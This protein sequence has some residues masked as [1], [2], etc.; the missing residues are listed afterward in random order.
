LG[1]KV[2]QALSHAVDRSRLGE[3]TNG[4]AIEA[5]CMVPIG[6]FGYIDD[7]E[8]AAIQNFDPGKAK[9]LLV[10]TPYEG[11]QNWPETTMHMRGKEENYNYALMANDIVA[12]L[13][14]NLGMNIN[15]Q[16]G[17]EASWRPELFK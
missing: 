7:Q 10:G 8:I 1:L 15:I 3:L 9:E 4:L 12:Q 6:V 2:R 17:P 14:A 16:V 11:G 13:Q 5:N